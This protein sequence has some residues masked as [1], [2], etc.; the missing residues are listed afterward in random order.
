MMRTL[1]VRDWL[2]L[3]EVSKVGEVSE[4]GFSFRLG[5]DCLRKVYIGVPSQFTHGPSDQWR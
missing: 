3:G 2:V 4:V 1:Y 5:Y